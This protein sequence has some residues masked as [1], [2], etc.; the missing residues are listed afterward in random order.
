[1]KMKEL[2]VSGSFKTQA[3]TDKERVS[4]SGMKIVI[5]EPD[6]KEFTEDELVQYAMRMF[7]IFK[8]ED[9]KIADYNYEGLIKI[10]VDGVK[11][12]KRKFPL[13]GVD[14]K[15]M[16]FE[17]LQYLAVAMGIREIPLY[18]S[19]SIREARER[20]YELFMKV[21]RKKKVLK[22][23]QDKQTLLEAIQRAYESQVRDGIMSQA[24]LEQKKSD[25]ISNSFNMI[26]D[27]NNPK[28]SYSFAKLP[29]LVPFKKLEKEAVA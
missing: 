16:D 17:Q 1:M 29:P 19:G 13:E 5:P 18:H 4:F 14:I 22:N 2:S 26:R 6:S 8:K 28:E 27:V 3:G 25:A 9:E 10:Y 24:E 15:E 23:V 20:T 11:E 7:P 21:V 12:S